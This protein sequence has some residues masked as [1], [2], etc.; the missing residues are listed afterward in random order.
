MTVVF[1]TKRSDVPTLTSVIERLTELDR[2]LPV[3]RTLY[4]Q[5]HYNNEKISFWRGTPWKILLLMNKNV[6][7]VFEDDYETIKNDWYDNINEDDDYE[8]ETGNERVE[9]DDDDERIR[10]Q[11]TMKIFFDAGLPDIKTLVD[12]MIFDMFQ[13]QIEND[14]YWLVRMTEDQVPIYE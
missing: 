3:R 10:S 7:T 4:Q 5:I 2:I 9:V 6:K 11:K 12:Q 8:Y 14:T 1:P 13:L